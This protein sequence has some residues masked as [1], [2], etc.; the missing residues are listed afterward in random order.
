MKETV[1]VPYPPVPVSLAAWLLLFRALCCFF[2]F[3]LQSWGA[4]L[5]PIAT[6]THSGPL[7]PWGWV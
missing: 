6:P 4:R 2:P 3:L 7:S 1:P 5:P